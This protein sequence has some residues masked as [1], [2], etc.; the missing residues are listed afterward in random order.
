M[1]DL[2]CLCDHILPSLNVPL[3]VLL[4]NVCAGIKMQVQQNIRT[5]SLKWEKKKK[6]LPPSANE[7]I[8]KLC[9]VHFS[10]PCFR[11]QSSY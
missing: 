5:L 3:D 1:S 2:E 9:S 4:F 10:C 8:L 6:N 7:E 11:L